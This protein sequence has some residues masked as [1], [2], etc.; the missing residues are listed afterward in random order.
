[1]NAMSA[2]A[3]RELM[4]RVVSQVVSRPHQGVGTRDLGRSLFQVAT[5]LLSRGDRAGAEAAW[6]ELAELAGRS[7]DTSLTIL[8]L[9]GPVLIAFI[10]GRL[11]EALALHEAQKARAQELGVTAPGLQKPPVLL[12]RAAEFL[13]EWEDP[14]RPV[15]ARRAVLLAHLGH[16]EEALT[17]RER[18]G[19]LGSDHDESGLHVLVDLLE[20]AVVCQDEDTAQRLM[21][22]LSPLAGEGFFSNAGHGVSIG[23]LCGGAAKFLGQ[24][25]EARG[26][27]NK[28]LEFCAKIRFRPET[29][30]IRLEL[31]ELLLE[32]YPDERPAAIEHLDFAIGEFRDMKM[33]PSL[34]RALRHR[35][36]LKA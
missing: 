30:L 28:G 17:I 5:R 22:R 6:S 36:L 34:E 12:G 31:A 19:D 24:P 14:G 15:Q 4:D 35:D 33:Q 11:E 16:R 2:L 25:A 27:Y 20:V 10:D 3:D 9:S 7:R 21:R 29:A 8:A 1:M 13:S 23:R 26:Y 18:F 32:H